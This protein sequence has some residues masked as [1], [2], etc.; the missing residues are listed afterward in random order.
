MESE[1]F[2]KSKQIDDKEKNNNP[3]VEIKQF[4]PKKIQRGL[5]ESQFFYLK[6][7]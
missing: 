3:K 1:L 2:Y 6:R 4:S 5:G 7:V